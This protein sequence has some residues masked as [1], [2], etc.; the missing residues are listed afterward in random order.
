MRFVCFTSAF[1]TYDSAYSV[2]NFATTWCGF[3]CSW[4]VYT[5]VCKLQFSILCSL[6]CLG[7]QCS[8]AVYI[9]VFDKRLRNFAIFSQTNRK[10]NARLDHSK[11]ANSNFRFEK[12]NIYI[13]AASRAFAVKDALCCF[14]NFAG[15]WFHWK[16][17]SIDKYLSSSNSQKS[18]EP[19][20]K[21]N[22]HLIW[23]NFTR[24]QCDQICAKSRHLFSKIVKAFF[25][26]LRVCNLVFEKNLILLF[27]KNI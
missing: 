4:I 11:R 14:L 26:I 3:Q 6:L 27:Q 7:F 20:R 16:M 1:V 2:L 25:G 22:K 18:D 24:N 8:Q 17:N 9:C 23:Q 13:F 10:I 19:D 21:S 5:C 15:A 12:W